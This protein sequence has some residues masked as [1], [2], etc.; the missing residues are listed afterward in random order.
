MDTVITKYIKRVQ[1]ICRKLLGVEMECY[2]GAYDINVYKLGNGML[3]DVS[4]YPPCATRYGVF[5]IAYGPDATFSDNPVYLWART[6]DQFE[7][8]L[9]KALSDN[10]G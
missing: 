8:N 10:A 9:K 7:E 3:M 5:V 1:K 2:Y 6:F 4:Y